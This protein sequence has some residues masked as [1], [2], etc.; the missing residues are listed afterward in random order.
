VNLILSFVHPTKAPKALGPYRVVRLD[1]DGVNG[2]DG[3]PVAH[4]RD[5]EWQV[6]GERY[7]R[8]D[9]EARVTIH[10][11]KSEQLKSRSF[12]PYGRFSA[13]NGIAYTDHKVFAF[14]DRRV[15]DWFCYDD[16]RHW[17]VMV[18]TDHVL[19]RGERA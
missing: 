1:A 3:F 11:E 8:L 14:V 9:C 6:G 18:L 5:Q 15:G 13:I 17:P 16:G 12:G 10:F 7:F 2:H 19:A 4:Y